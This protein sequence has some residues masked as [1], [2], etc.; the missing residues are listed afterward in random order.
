MKF[1]LPKDWQVN[2]RRF[3]E[4]TINKMIEVDGGSK[5]LQILLETG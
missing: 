4:D 3:T 2:N 5:K 1:I